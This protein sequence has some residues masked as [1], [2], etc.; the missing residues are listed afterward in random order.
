MNAKVGRGVSACP[1]ISEETKNAISAAEEQNL[2][3]ERK[4]PAPSFG[5]SSSSSSRQ[6]G[7]ADK[8]WVMHGGE[9]PE[10]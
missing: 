9:F 10:L 5:L 7:I 2:S 6:P 4:E 1:D 3:N 8:W